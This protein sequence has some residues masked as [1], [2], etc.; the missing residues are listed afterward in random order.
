MSTNLR[1]A[2]LAAGAWMGIGP[3][4]DRES[5]RS[6]LGEPDERD[7]D[8]HVWRYGDLH[9]RF[10][11]D[12]LQEFF[13]ETLPDELLEE[14]ASHDR[15]GVWTADLESGARFVLERERAGALIRLRAFKVPR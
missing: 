5:V 14:H 3:G 15:V 7:A 12:T 6:T 11:A 10:D 9:L 13:G 1:H 2:T 4:A 8:D